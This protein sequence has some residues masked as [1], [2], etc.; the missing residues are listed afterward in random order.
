MPCWVKNRSNEAFAARDLVGG[1][2][3]D[4]NGTPLIVLYEKHIYQG[5]DH[6]E[7]VKEE[8]NDVGWIL[9]LLLHKDKRV[10]EHCD[11]GMAQGYRWIKQ[12]P[13]QSSGSDD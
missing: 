7:T 10:F 9:K 3:Y 6:A 1:E 8:G 5:K 2:N 11:G 13:N 4:W 12:Q